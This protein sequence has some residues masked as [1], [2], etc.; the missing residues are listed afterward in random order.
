MHII[1]NDKP[2]SVATTTKATQQRTM[3][4]TEQAPTKWQEQVWQLFILTRSACACGARCLNE[5]EKS[6]LLLSPSLA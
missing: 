6:R 2:G 4:R 3:A 5:G 1:M